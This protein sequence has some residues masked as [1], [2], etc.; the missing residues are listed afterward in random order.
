M[1]KEIKFMTKYCLQQT[2]K[3][4]FKKKLMTA[5]LKIHIRMYSY[6]TNKSKHRLAV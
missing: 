2:T 5:V 3:N 1:T 6:F 4:E